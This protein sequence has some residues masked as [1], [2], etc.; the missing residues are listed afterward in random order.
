[1]LKV[2]ISIVKDYPDHQFVIAGAP[3]QKP[4]I[5]QPYTTQKNVTLLND[6][7]YDLLSLSYAALVT[8][9]TATLETALFKVPQVVCYKG[10]RISYEIAKRVINLKFISLV[11]LILDR[12]VVTELIQN[13]FNK[14]TL[15]KELDRILD[16]YH[17]SV[18]FLDYFDLE[19][20]LGGKGASKKV[21]KS[22]VKA[23]K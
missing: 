13:K 12:E 8:S 3:G 9:G 14:T 5:Y 11:N 15:K 7:T 10:S 17:R 4:E 23:L 19:K 21:A 2:M 22:I 20:T 6:K 1:M 16:D 18:L